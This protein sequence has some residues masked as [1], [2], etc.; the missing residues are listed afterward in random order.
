MLVAP[1][2]AHLLNEILASAAA[3]G[4]VQGRQ[5]QAWPRSGCE[6]EASPLGWEEDYGI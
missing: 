4:V 2:V 3:E 6:R 5:R 1:E